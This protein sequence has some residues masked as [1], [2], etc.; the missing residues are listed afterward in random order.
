MIQWIFVAASVM[1]LINLLSVVFYLPFIDIS[2][3][4]GEYDEL[5]P[6]VYLKDCVT[7]FRKL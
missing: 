7:V 3:S 6:Y 2:L 1:C 5:I 4:F